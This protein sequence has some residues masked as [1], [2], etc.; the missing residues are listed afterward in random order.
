MEKIALANTCIKLTKSICNVGKEFKISIQFDNF[1][2]L[3]TSFTERTKVCSVQKKEIWKRNKN[4]LGWGVETGLNVTFPSLITDTNVCKKIC[5]ESLSQS[6]LD[7]CT[8]D[9]TAR[10]CQL[11]M[12][13]QN[14]SGIFRQ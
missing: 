9:L 10:D 4:R 14:C 1:H 7:S 3:S 6:P 8:L 2:F 12:I 13:S 11:R 5:Q